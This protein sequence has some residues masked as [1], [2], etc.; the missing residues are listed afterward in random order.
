MDEETLWILKMLSERRISAQSASR[1]LRALEL[2]E[3]TEKS[4]ADMPVTTGVSKE[5]AS[6]VPELQA[7]KQSVIQEEKPGVDERTTI[8]E[9]IFSVTEE[10][11]N[12]EIKLTGESIGEE[13]KE[14][15]AIEPGSYQESR[16]SEEAEKEI[17]EADMDDKEKIDI[18][19][20][21]QDAIR[22]SVTAEATEKLLSDF[23]VTEEKPPQEV[24]E[25]LLS[26]EESKAEQLTGE[27]QVSLELQEST[28]DADLD[29]EEE[30]EEGLSV[31]EADE[32]KPKLAQTEEI[33]E[34]LI[35]EE[36]APEHGILTEV[37]SELQQDYESSLSVIDV[38]DGIEMIIEKSA[39][40]V[41][42]K[43]WDQ[44]QVKTEAGE[45]TFSILQVED[46]VKIKTETDATIYIPSKVG[47][48]N[49]FNVSGPVNVENYKNDMVINSDTGDIIV[50]G[51]VGTVKAKSIEGSIVLE[52]CYGNF[53]LESRSGN[54]AVRKAGSA[55]LKNAEG[56]AGL[57]EDRL[58]RS[59]GTPVVSVQSNSG[60]IILED[61]QGNIDA[62]S[63]DKDI[64]I[65]RCRGQSVVAESSGGNLIIKDVANEIN[66]KNENGEISVEDFF[67]K[68]RITAK[69]TKVSLKR[70]GDAEIYIESDGGDINIEDCYADAYVNSGTGN[71]RIS[72]GNLSF[73]AMGRIELKMANGDAYLSRRTF[74]DVR[75]SI[76]SGN[77]EL[78]MEKLN[79][80]GSGYISVYKGNIIFRVSPSFR[81][82]VNALA[83]RKRIHL[84]LP[85]KIVERGK[86][87]LRGVLNDGGSKIDLIAPDGEIMLQPL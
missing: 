39:G 16:E 84:D 18:A 78:N 19:Q 14:I 42:I 8:E 77:A 40:E 51:G 35:A 72:G 22:T 15:L 81:F 7:V 53:W 28:P 24:Q 50:R 21:E 80:G 82:E 65:E 41:K 68:I 46:K 37:G 2:L 5:Q 6:S 86:G 66:L 57:R 64:K 59:N 38:P 3:K 33:T 76:E 48:I 31:A 29:A 67:G 79:S 44:P 13:I 52:N 27:P 1:I 58:N 23:S 74:E 85:V 75:I 43:G 62:R 73:A 54:I 87:Q 83:Q 56:I 10:E 49:I 12:R 71:V 69:N 34:P 45:D 32:G 4:I 11:Q 47:R 17:Q 9:E 36:T 61:I 30:P 70:S 55:Y 60:K 63:G 20:E 26:E 25:K